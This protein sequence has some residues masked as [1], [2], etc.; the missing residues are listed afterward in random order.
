MNNNENN[1]DTEYYIKRMEEIRKQQD[2]QLNKIYTQENQNIN[3]ERFEKY[4][5]GKIIHTQPHKI[6]DD[7]YVF[8]AYNKF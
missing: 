8:M 4:R 5:K 6:N 1:E 3:Y 2:I 7:D